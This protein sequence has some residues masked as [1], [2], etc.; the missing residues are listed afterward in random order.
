MKKLKLRNTKRIAQRAEFT[1]KPGS[2]PR[3][4]TLRPC[5]KGAWWVCPRS[6]MLKQPCCY[7]SCERNCSLSC[8]DS[9]TQCPACGK[10]DS[11]EFQDHTAAFSLLGQGPRCPKLRPKLLYSVVVTQ[12]QGQVQYPPLTDR[13]PW[14]V[15]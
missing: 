14:E 4:L 1:S 11:R 15:V 8:S 12:G 9:S 6:P 10:G 5:L 3:A 13:P 2:P 7:F